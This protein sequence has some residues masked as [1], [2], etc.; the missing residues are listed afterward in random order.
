MNMAGTSETRTPFARALRTS[1]G[2]N[3]GDRVFTTLT[4]VVAASAV[5]ILLVIAL[6]LFSD[7]RLSVVR[8]GFGFLT[9]TRWDPGFLD[10]GA[11]AYIYGTIMTSLVA[12]VLATPVA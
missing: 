11:A 1:R 12:L 9:G 7:A 2:T 6:L 10:F 4:L 3:V 5:A 8:F